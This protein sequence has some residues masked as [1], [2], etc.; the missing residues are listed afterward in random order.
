MERRTFD[1]CCTLLILSAVM[2]ASF[3]SENV[4]APER[5]LVTR[6]TVGLVLSGGG[7]RGAA[8]V[9]VIKVL[10]DLQIPVDFVAGTSMGAIVGGLYA[11]GMTADELVHVIET[12]DW[13]ALLTDRPPRAQRSFRRKSDDIGFLVDFDLGIDKSGLIFPEGFIQG[14]NLEIALKRLALPAI[15]I[16]DFDELPI[17]FRAVATDIVTGEA[18]VIDSGDLAAAMRASMSAPGI[19]KPVRSDGRILVDGGVANNL[20]VQIVRDM[21]ADILIVVD[22]GFPLLSEEQ[23]GSALA[24][25]KQMLTI[26]INGRAQDQIALLD[27][28]DILISPNLGDF[29][30]QDFQR[31]IEAQHLGNEKARELS[32]RL[33][34]LSISNEKY[35]AY[36]KRVERNRHDVP[37]ID[38]VVVE[39]E[40]RLSPRVI[41]ARLTE[42]DGKPLDLGQLESDISNIYGFD[43]FETV[44]YDVVND[45]G[46]N[47]LLVRA[48][49]KSWGPNYLRFGVNLEDDFS[50]NS[51]YNVAAR[52]TRTEINRLGGEFRAELQIGETPRLFAELYQPLDYASRWFVNPQIEFARSGS[53]LFDNSG[54]QI[55][56]IGSDDARLSLDGG[57][58]FGNWGGFRVG[59][60]RVHSDAELRIG[61]PGFPGGSAQTTSLTAVL[62]TTQLIAWRC[63]GQ[64]QTLV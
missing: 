6:P 20:P 2:S 26:L 23:L 15:S 24:V 44:T 51:N 45:T 56:Q 61:P 9:G 37:V 22:V 38:S 64:V 12:A 41:E 35:L 53:G 34:E 46:R 28:D 33:A 31:L 40:S 27:A 8:H 63:Q 59:V 18:V 62:N 47:T 50:G 48:T 32:G 39:N 54:L 58:Q 11:S 19:F 10:D 25:T 60:S 30:S 7:A 16:D 21:G 42:Q 36:R 13:S 1:I 17:P 14:Q 4:S 43:T 3:A 5:E 55:A 57:R 29:G 52:L 49:E